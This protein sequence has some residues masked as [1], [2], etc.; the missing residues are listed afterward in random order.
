MAQ[1]RGI[2]MDEKNFDELLPI[3]EQ[4]K[5]QGYWLVLAGHEIGESGSL[6]TRKTMLHEL[7][8]YLRDNAPEIWL[9]PV[10]EIASYI[11]AHRSIDE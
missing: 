2:P 5:V 1:V 10:V 8:A 3:I 4:A 11:E 6:T 9:A 7:L